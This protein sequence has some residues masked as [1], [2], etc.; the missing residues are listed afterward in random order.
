MS[1]F[2]ALSPLLLL[3]NLD[4]KIKYVHN[5][6]VVS[7]RLDSLDM[8]FRVKVTPVVHRK[9]HNYITWGRKKTN[10]IL[11]TMTMYK[12]IF[13]KYIEAKGLPKELAY[14]PIVESALNPKA[15][16]P[17]GATGLWQFMGPTARAKGLVINNIVDERIDPVRSTQIAL[18]YL[19]ELHA[20]FGDWTLALAAYNCGP[21]KIRSILRANRKARDVWDILPYL[22]VETQEY[23][24]S[25]IAA[26]YVATYFESYNLQPNQM[27]TEE[28]YTTTLIVFDRLN[29]LDISKKI[30]IG[31][32]LLKKLNPSYRTGII[33]KS[34]KGNYLII[35]HE[36]VNDYF[37]MCE[38]NVDVLIAPNQILLTSNYLKGFDYVVSDKS[39]EFPTEY[40]DDND[41][42]TPNPSREDQSKQNTNF[43]FLNDRMNRYI[44]ISRERSNEPKGFASLENI[45]GI[46]IIVEQTF[47][48]TIAPLVNNA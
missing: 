33:P 26:T 44:R 15:V 17:M 6:T 46:S 24:P 13:D 10:E 22:P 4:K 43:H 23:I 36:K 2:F 5:N 21:G 29:L 27:K 30:D 40:D 37:E 11:G 7:N 48:G 35:P 41:E 16:S 25:L 12:P 47:G 14:L 1:F 3:A 45:E 39:L 19:A 28:F 38:G 9:I 8:S 31:Y 34:V 20:M 42:K 32:N 18:D